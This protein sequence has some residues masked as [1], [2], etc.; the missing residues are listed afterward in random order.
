ME[1]AGWHDGEGLG[2][3]VTGMAEALTADGGKLSSKDK[4]GLGYVGEKIERDPSKRFASTSQ[5][6]NIRITTAYDNPDETDPVEP[7]NRRS[8]PTSN[9]NRTRQI[10]NVFVKP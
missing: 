5:Q 8:E 9:K 10:K 4:A 7:G 6:S 3:S 1:R 2:S